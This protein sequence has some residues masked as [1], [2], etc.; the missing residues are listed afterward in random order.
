MPPAARVGDSTGHPGVV[1][2]PGVPN[3]LVGGMPAAVLGDIHISGIPPLAGPQPPTPFP[4]GSATVL[5]GGRPALRFGDVSG[6][7]GPIVIGMPNVQIGG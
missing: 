5:I 3:V 1:A 6:N 2:G 4:K 7:G